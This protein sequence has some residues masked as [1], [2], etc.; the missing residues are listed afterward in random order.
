VVTPD[1]KVAAKGTGTVNGNSGYGFVLYGYDGCLN[2]GASGC[3]PGEPDRFR[4]VVWEGERSV[5][6]P[7]SLYDTYR[8]ADF[9]VDRALPWPAMSG[10][11]TIHR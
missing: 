1:G 2:G 7:G 5:P 10:E 11:V 3:R 6:T 9:D 4:A 8:G